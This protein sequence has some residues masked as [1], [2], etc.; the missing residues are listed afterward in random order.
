MKKLYLV[1]LFLVLST[2]SIYS[3]EKVS[4]FYMSVFSKHFYILASDPNE[5][6]IRFVNIECV[7]KDKLVRQTYLF[8]ETKNIEQF[9]E[10]LNHLK[11]T[12]TK[13]ILVAKSNNV[14]DFEKMVEYRPFR[15]CAGFLL[16]TWNFDYNVN[17]SATFKIIKGKYYMVIES[18]PLVSKENEYITSE[19]LILVLSN[20]SDFD[21]LIKSLNPTNIDNYYK[22]KYAR[23]KLFK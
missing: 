19:G 9:I 3:Q 20:I 15:Y 10:Y 17:I 21:S 1:L 23:D 6:T 8:F 14:S 7:P 13:W 5:E 12:Y 18:D 22:K 2:T 4:D 11:S 16:G